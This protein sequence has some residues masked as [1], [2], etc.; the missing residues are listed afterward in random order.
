MAIGVALGLGGTVVSV[1]VDLWLRDLGFSVAGLVASHRTNPVVWLAELLPLGLGM[2]GAWSGARVDLASGDAPRLLELEE[3]ARALKRSDAA[4]RMLADGLLFEKRGTIDE[5]NEAA[6]RIFGCAPE[7]LVG[8]PIAKFVPG[9][10]TGGSG[11]QVVRCTAQGEV[12]AISWRYAATDAQGRPFEA[13]V[14]S[15]RVADNRAVHVVRDVTDERRELDRLREIQRSLVDQRDRATAQS[16]GRR[17]VLVNMGHEVRTPLTSMLGYLEMLAE[18][19][20]DRAEA[21]DDLERIRAS[22]AQ[23]LALLDKIHDQSMIEAGRLALVMGPVDLGELAADV[24]ATVR[25]LLQASRSVLETEIAGE[26][27][28]VHADRQRLRQILLTLLGNACQYTSDGT[29]R[30]VATARGEGRDATVEVTVAD[31]GRGMPEELVK[32]LFEPL[33]G[34]RPARSGLGVAIAFELVRL[35]GGAIAVESAVGQG[36]RFTFT[37]QVAHDE[38]KIERV[39]R[40]R[41]GLGGQGR[42][43]LLAD[44]PGLCDRLAAELGARGVEVASAGTATGALEAAEALKPTALGVDLGLVRASPW[45]ELGL[46]CASPHFARLPVAAFVVRG[47]RARVL[48]VA[49]LLSLPPDRKR[50]QER[51][52]IVG[53]PQGPALVVGARSAVRALEEAGW[54]AR[55][56]TAAEAAGLVD[57]AG[58]LVVDLLSQQAEGLKLVLEGTAL[59][60]VIGLLPSAPSD[61]DRTAAE[62]AL[63]G[64]LERAGTARDDALA[65]LVAA[66]SEP[67]A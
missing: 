61:A 57:E 32:G 17:Q 19:I 53:D 45:S 49:G 20:V 44:D 56:V 9:L 14:H 35:M 3:Q 46:L 34:R 12:V 10:E 25:P 48:R 7:A 18:Q 50:L 60:P 28:A 51:A 21:V 31:T 62:A 16:E 6:G 58:L 39:V 36:T 37:L 59:P 15:S 8:Q 11:R 64:H 2:L 26:L 13:E 27:P 22:A 43:V 5:A 4:L 1:G 23:V 65:A 55:E 38:V 63:Q 33:H 52:A 30:L 29:I 40:A 24:S 54:K 66:L 41:T 42:V 47:A 67:Q